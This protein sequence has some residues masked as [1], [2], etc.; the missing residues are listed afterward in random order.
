MCVGV[1][2]WEVV[3][4]VE[5]CG[6]GMRVN[7]NKT[8]NELSDISVPSFFMMNWNDTRQRLINY[9]SQIISPAV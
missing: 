8:N 7:I 2:A 5:V 9:C 6:G 1:C 4:E 3:D